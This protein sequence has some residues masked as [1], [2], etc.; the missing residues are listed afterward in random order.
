M[1][2]ICKLSSIHHAQGFVFFSNFLTETSIRNV[3]HFPNALEV[4]MAVKIAVRL[5][6]AVVIPGK[7]SAR[8]LSSSISTGSSFLS[9][10][11]GDAFVVVYHTPQLEVLEART[12]L[13]LC[14]S[15][16]YNLAD[17]QC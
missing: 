16:V 5:S 3:V 11:T 14:R 1:A 12:R 10:K 9:C 15:A 2:L 13:L 17:S 7:N 8:W 6:F 4:F